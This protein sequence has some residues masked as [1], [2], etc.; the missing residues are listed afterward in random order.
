[1]L[2]TILSQQIRQLIQNRQ[3][4]RKTKSTEA[5]LSRNRNLNRSITKRLN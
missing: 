1:M 3:I 4:P 2:Q 5:D